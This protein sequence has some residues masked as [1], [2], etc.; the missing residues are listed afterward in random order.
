M[1]DSSVPKGLRT[2]LIAVIIFRLLA[3]PIRYFLAPSQIN[4]ETFSKYANLPFIGSIGIF[5]AILPL[6]WIIPLILIIKNK[7]I[8]YQ[9]SLLFGFLLIYINVLD[10]MYLISPNQTLFQVLFFFYFFTGVTIIGLA[11]ASLRYLRSSEVTPQSAAVPVVEVQHAPNYVIPGIVAVIFAAVDFSPI[12]F[13]GANF[14]VGGFLG[15]GSNPLLPA[16]TVLAVAL[17]SGW[18]CGQSLLQ[19]LWRGDKAPK[20]GTGVSFGALNGAIAQLVIYGFS[21]ILIIAAPVGAIL[22]AFGGV[23]GVS[24][25]FYILKW[26]AFRQTV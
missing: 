1:Y 17:L 7:K 5:G 6:V 11:A 16:I 2:A 26:T 8:G 13:F 9:L 25:L 23:V 10:I 3:F 4:P 21:S 22:G 14:G 18:M 24:L 15:P 20:S 12:F 19:V